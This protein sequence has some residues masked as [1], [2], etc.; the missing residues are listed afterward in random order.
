MDGSF[1]LVVWCRKH[2]GGN[3]ILKK[4]HHQ[5][6]QQKNNLFDDAFHTAQRVS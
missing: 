6:D 1:A 3:L 5:H 4:W 2:E